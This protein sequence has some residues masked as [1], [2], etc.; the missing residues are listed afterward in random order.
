MR[1]LCEAMDQVTGELP[2]EAAQRRLQDTEDRIIDEDEGIE[3]DRNINNPGLDLKQ[4]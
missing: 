2:W 4:N 1:N 3:A